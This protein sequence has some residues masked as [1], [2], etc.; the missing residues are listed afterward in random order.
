MLQIDLASTSMLAPM[1]VLQFLSLKLRVRDPRSIE[2]R[3][4][5]LEII[6]KQLK[7]RNVR[8]THN[9]RHWRVQGI[10]TKSAAET[11]FTNTDGHQISVHSRRLVALT[12]NLAMPNAD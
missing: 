9:N 8:S 2:L 6:H 1:N 11:R 5:E 12:S 10:A 7:G 4:V 3:P